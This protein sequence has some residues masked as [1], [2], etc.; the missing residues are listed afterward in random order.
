MDCFLRILVVSALLAAPAARAQ[1]SSSVLTAGPTIG[2]SIGSA[3]VH[4]GLLLEYSRYLESGFE[5]FARAPVLLT[6]VPAGA[7]TSTG[8]GW[9]FA[10]GLSL[11]VRYLFAE[12]AVRPWVGAQV[13]ASIL[14]TTP[15]VTWFVGP[16]AG[17]GLEWVLS[18]SIA[19][20]ARATWDLFIHLNEPSVN[21]L[22]GALTVSILL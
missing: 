16:G 14:I 2:V 9:V 3:R 7:D 13:G 1:Y 15:S 6:Q 19:L 17:A 20:G 12:E 21:Q 22:G 4:S 5:F 10:T 11:G 18:E 8:A